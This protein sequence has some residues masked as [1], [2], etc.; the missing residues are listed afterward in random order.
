MIWKVSRRHLI[1]EL[2]IP[3]VPNSPR[4][5]FRL[6]HENHLLPSPIERWMEY[7]QAR[8]DTSHDYSEEKASQALEKVGEFITDS[9]AIYETMRGEDWE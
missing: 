8:I 2:D 5:V 4:P 7:S 6:A 3:D 1:E 9:I